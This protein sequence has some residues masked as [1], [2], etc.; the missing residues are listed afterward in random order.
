MFSLLSM[1]PFVKG[2]SLDLVTPTTIILPLEST[3]IPPGPTVS[4]TSPPI[5][6]EKTMSV[7]VGFNLVTKISPAHAPSPLK[8]VS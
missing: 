7:P 3:L 6:V 4:S 5:N 8:L 1:T 2:K